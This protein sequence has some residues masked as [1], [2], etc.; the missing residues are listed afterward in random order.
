MKTRCI[1]AIVASSLTLHAQ[2]TIVSA[3][4]TDFPDGQSWNN[5]AVTATFVPGPTKAYK[6]PGGAI[7]LNVTGTMNGSGT[8]TISVPDP[9]TITPRGS[10]WRFTICPNASSGCQTKQVPVSGASIDISAQLSAI[11]ASPR[12]PAKAWTYGYLDAE[13]QS[14]PL[15]GGMYWNVTAR[16]QRCWTGT[17]WATCSSGGGGNLPAN[18][19]GA[20]NN[21]GS[22]GLA[23]VPPFAVDV[24]QAPYSAVCD[25]STDDSAAIQA[26]LDN[27]AAVYIPVRS[28]G[29][30]SCEIPEGLTLCSGGGKNLVYNALYGNGQ[31]LEYSG[32]GGAIQTS[33]NCRQ[34]LVSGAY[35]RLTTATGSPTAYLLSEGDGSGIIENSKDAA[36]VVGNAYT[37]ISDSDADAAITIENIQSAGN[38]VLGVADYT[39][40]LSGVWGGTLSVSNT[41]RLQISSS[42]F[43]DTLNSGSSISQPSG[44]TELSGTEFD[45]VLT[46]TGSGNQFDTTFSSVRLQSLVFSGTNIVVAGDAEFE[47]PGVPAITGTASGSLSLNDETGVPYLWQNGIFTNGQYYNVAGNTLPVCNSGLISGGF[48]INLWV[49]DA[50]SLSGPYVGSGSYTAP[51][52]CGYDGVSYSWQMT[53]QGNLT[54]TLTPGTYP[55][56]TGANTLGNG[57]IFTGSLVGLVIHPPSSGVQNILIDTNGAPTGTLSLYG[58]QVTNI[59]AGGTQT[60]LLS[61]TIVLRNLPGHGTPGVV[62]ADVS[63]NLSIGGTPP[64]AIIYSVAGTPLPTCDSSIVGLFLTVSDATNL[65]GAYIGSGPY[66]SPVYCGYDGVNYAWQ[67]YAPPSAGGTYVG[68]AP[69]VVSSGTISCPTCSVGSGSNV[70]VNGGSPLGTANLANN[71]GAG[72]IDFTNPAGSTVNATLHN[73]TISG[74]SLGNNLDTLTFGTHLAAGGSSYNGSANVTIT[75]DATNANTASTIVARDASGNFAANIISAALNGNALTATSAAGLSGNP[76]I[77]V[78]NFT[79]L[80]TLT[81]PSASISNAA[82]AHASTTVNGQTCT[83]GS[84]CTVSSAGVASFNTRTGPVTLTAADVNATGASV[85][86]NGT[87]CAIGSTCYPPVNA[88]TPITT[89]SVNLG[90]G[91]YASYKT[92]VIFNAQS[93]A[94]SAFAVTLPT[95]TL[96][97]Y[98]CVKNWYNGSAFNTG[99]ITVTVANAGTQK[100]IYAQTSFAGTSISSAGAVGDY[101]CFTGIS[102][103]QW[104]FNPSAGTW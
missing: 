40:I 52:Y 41:N 25:G 72:E 47:A 69:I 22:G 104:D 15:P 74:I 78:T 28:G 75:S 101:G 33:G 97:A 88:F 63:G 95:P 83:L 70:T 39:T 36:T 100:I 34:F 61:D 29:A 89:P 55:I 32:T 38:V 96:G 42:I 43:K 24:T 65:Y 86:I 71:T 56:A 11:A 94:A 10:G 44:P 66:T 62:N 27:N 57:T 4:I 8:F 54:G 93:S 58:D 84:T 77:S 79:A 5:G 49:S 67:M 37:S 50:T 7:P 23:W 14:V 87:S 92:G 60:T 102:S 2:S 30:I 35:V 46:L 17:A 1:L 90:G 20:L 81:L 51:V 45:G 6:W 48:G 31:V 53:S 99:V 12:F 76:N 13:I 85:T 16:V 98:W 68:A 91:S 21:D 9:T 26:A 64:P 19:F 80:G 3:T 73:T 103:T 18:A 82:L 59:G